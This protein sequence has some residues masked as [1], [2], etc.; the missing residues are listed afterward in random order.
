MTARIIVSGF[1]WGAKSSKHGADASDRDSTDTKLAAKIKGKLRDV[2][3]QLNR[4][5]SRL[6][7][8]PVPSP[9]RGGASPSQITPLDGPLHQYKPWENDANH[10]LNTL[11]PIMPYQRRRPERKGTAFSEVPF[12][13]AMVRSNSLLHSGRPFLR[14]T[15]Q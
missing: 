6:T 11:T 14:H 10:Q 2:T 5:T 1:V 7:R 13:E 15:W 3:V 12:H 8:S 9:S 4:S